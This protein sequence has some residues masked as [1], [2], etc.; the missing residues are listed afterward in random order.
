MWNQR[1]SSKQRFPC[2]PV[3]LGNPDSVTYAFSFQF[4]FPPQNDKYPDTRRNKTPAKIDPNPINTTLPS[5]TRKSTSLPIKLNDTGFRNFHKR[6]KYISTSHLNDASFALLRLHPVPAVNVA[7]M[8]PKAPADGNSRYLLPITDSAPQRTIVVKRSPLEYFYQDIMKNEKNAINFQLANYVASSFGWTVCLSAV[9]ST[10]NPQRNVIN[11][12]FYDSNWT[13]FTGGNINV[14]IL[15]M[16]MKGLKILKAHRKRIP[17]RCQP[18]LAVID[19]SNRPMKTQFHTGR[20]TRRS[21]SH[22][23][24][25]SLQ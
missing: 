11:D 9:W 12:A 19:E 23:C 3:A 24:N 1:F 5:S 2:P 25:W 16:V 8:Q 22:H 17:W 15:L 7:V 13:H 21:Q 4:M 14:P 10:K 18:V 20:W 6:S